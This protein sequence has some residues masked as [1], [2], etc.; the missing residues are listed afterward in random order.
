MVGGGMG[1]GSTRPPP[2]ARDEAMTS[3]E[4]PKGAR[5][6]HVAKR[7]SSGTGPRGQSTSPAIRRIL[8]PTG[9]VTTILARAGTWLFRPRRHRRSSHHERMNHLRAVRRLISRA[10]HVG[11]NH[12]PVNAAP[13]G[14]QA[15][16]GPGTDLIDLQGAT[17]MPDATTHSDDPRPRFAR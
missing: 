5:R 10:Q 13:R 2:W 6:R 9:I 11:R 8:S 14:D 16:R 12:L 3:A 17:P 15:R 1:P 4:S 7:A